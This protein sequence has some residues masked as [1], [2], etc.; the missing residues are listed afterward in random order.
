MTRAEIVVDLAAIRDNVRTIAAF[1]G[2]PVMHVVKANGYGHGLLESARAGRA[3]GATWL[4]VAGVE[5]ALAL[6]AGGDSGPILAWLITASDDVAAAIGAGVDVAAYTVADL[7]RIAETGLTARV[8][9]KLDTGLTRGGASRPDWTALF[10]RARAGELDGSWKIT[11]IWSHFVASEEPDETINDE[12]EKVF[13]EGVDEAR[14]AGLAPEVIHLANSAGALLRPSS[15]FDLVRIGI[16]SYGLEPARGVSPIPLRPAMRVVAEV[17]LV[18]D[19]PAG[20]GVSYN[21]RWVAPADTRVALVPVGY[22][23]GIP[24]A[25]SNR[26]DVAIYGGYRAPIRG[27]ICMDQFVVDVFG[28]PTILVGDEVVLWGDPEQGVPSAQDWAE[29]AGT[30]SYEV[31]T[32][33]GGRLSRRYEDLGGD[34]REELA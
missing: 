12:Q 3:G 16:A 31:V 25:A 28:E 7:D 11:G 19:V 4:G 20:Q 10:E 21:H 6:R 17:A 9:L 5:E 13:R 27:T 32:R 14:A 18:K 23:D 29:A 33:I 2:T 22:A 26:A 8:Q 15:R 30:I 34:S 24:R 1:T